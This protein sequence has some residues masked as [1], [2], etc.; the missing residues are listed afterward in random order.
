[1]GHF[2]FFETRAPSDVWNYIPSRMF[3]YQLRSKRTET[4]IYKFAKTE[5]SGVAE[6]CGVVA[7]RRD[8]FFFGWLGVC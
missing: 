2:V 6:R 7:R 1:M 5:T 4:K 3:L 8:G